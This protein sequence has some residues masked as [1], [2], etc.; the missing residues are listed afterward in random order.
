MQV[1]TLPEWMKAEGLSDSEV[2]DMIGR[3]RTSISRFRRGETRPDYD[4]MILFQGISKGAV[5]LES[6]ARIKSAESAT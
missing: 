6:W 1:K 2:A 5:A 4:T 3:H